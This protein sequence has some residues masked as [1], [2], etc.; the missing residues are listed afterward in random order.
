MPH[1]SYLYGNLPRLP[2][3][4]SLSMCQSMSSYHSLP[5]LSNENELKDGSQR[6]VKHCVCSFKT[7]FDF[8]NIV[9]NHYSLRNTFVDENEE[10]IDG[11]TLS[12]SNNVLEFGSGL[13]DP[14]SWTRLPPSN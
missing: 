1:H 12:T 6:T 13:S 11:S 14:S 8:F 7:L 2:I 3:L 4:R 9:Q 10:T 5:L